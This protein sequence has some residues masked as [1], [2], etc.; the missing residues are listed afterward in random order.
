MSHLTPGECQQV[1][2]LLTRFSCLFSTG[3]HDIGRTG[4]T[5]HRIDSQGAAPIRQPSHRLPLAMREEAQRAIADMQ[6]KELIEQSCSPWTTPIVLVR[7]K[8][9]GVRFCVEYRKVNQVTK[10]DSYPLPRIDHTLDCLQARNGSR[11]WFS[12][13]ASTLKNG[14][15]QVE[16]E[17]QD[18]EDCLNYLWR[19][20]AV[21]RYAIW[22]M[23]CSSHVRASHGPS[24]GWSTS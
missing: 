8:D 11:R 22:T 10:K 3:P 4:L 17:A 9:G 23:Q 1:R 15:R 16:M 6:D 20:V 5:R 14:Y 21:H 19:P 2:G 18:K 24:A 7:K 12:P 13:P